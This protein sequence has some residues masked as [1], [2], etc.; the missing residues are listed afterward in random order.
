MRAHGSSESAPFASERLTGKLVQTSAQR[1]QCR[2]TLMFQ[3]FHIFGGR[4]QGAFE[5]L[6]NASVGTH[7]TK[8]R[9][10]NIGSAVTDSAYQLMLSLLV[11]ELRSASSQSLP[12]SRPVALPALSLRTDTDEAAGVTGV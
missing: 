3:I 6:Y 8:V 10:D 9:R 11:A 4:L 5:R 7:T 1:L 12:M 2:F